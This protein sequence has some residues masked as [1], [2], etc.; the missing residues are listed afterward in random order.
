MSAD[1]AVDFGTARTLV[2]VRGKGIVVD[3]P[4]IAAVDLP[5]NRLIALAARR[6]VY[7]AAA[8]AR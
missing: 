4:T 6:L 3:E 2:A 5:R 8:R 7:A 1:I